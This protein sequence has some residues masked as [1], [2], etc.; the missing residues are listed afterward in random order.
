MSR[1]SSQTHPSNSSPS[2]L[3]VAKLVGTDKVTTHRYHNMYEKYLSP[4]RDRHETIKFLEIGLGCGM[5]YGPGASY[6]LWTRY[7]PKIDLYFVEYDAECLEKWR[8]KLYN[9]KI[10]TGDQADPEFLK[11]LMRETGG[12]FD[13]IGESSLKQN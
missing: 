5:E 13:V 2:F 10:F 3:E 7:F 12:D 6:E 1:K 11:R 4:L 9:V 8:S